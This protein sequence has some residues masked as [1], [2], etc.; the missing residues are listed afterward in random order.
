MK[1]QVL[2]RDA[3][4]QARARDAA[5]FA[6]EL[7]RLSTPP[8]QREPPPLPLPARRLERAAGARPAPRAP[9]LRKPR[10]AAA[11]RP[12]RAA[13]EPRPPR[14]L[15]PTPDLSGLVSYYELA[16]ELGLPRRRL[17][18][19]ICRGLF[20]PTVPGT[21][22]RAAHFDQAGAEAIR[23]YARIRA[24]DPSAPDFTP[25]ELGPG[26]CYLSTV[27]AAIHV[28]RNTLRRWVRSGVIQPMPYRTA[29]GYVFT[30]AAASAAVTYAARPKPQPTHCRNGHLLDEADN[31]AG[32]EYNGCPICIRASNRD[33]AARYRARQK[34]A[35]AK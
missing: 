22:H 20:T 32:R 2:D 6:R 18:N 25:P 4:K 28:C 14:P 11:S 19:W 9:R 1:A 27:A 35:R 30:E 15:K 33:A 8:E 16:A 26:E 34:A 23:E 21:T 31:R 17:R 24:L 29:R 13:R 3:L 7:A 12:E 10:P 5:F